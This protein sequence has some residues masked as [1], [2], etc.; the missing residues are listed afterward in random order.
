M[1][2]FAGVD[3]VDNVNKLI[4]LRSKTRPHNDKQNPIPRHALSPKANHRP[5]P[6]PPKTTANDSD[7]GNNSVSSVESHFSESRLKYFPSSCCLLMA[8]YIARQELR[9]PLPSY[10]DAVKHLSTG[11]RL[12]G[13]HQHFF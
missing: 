7:S 1:I 2:L 6:R 13:T 4:S 9:P 3:N 12:S 5:P 10:D 8:V 11:S